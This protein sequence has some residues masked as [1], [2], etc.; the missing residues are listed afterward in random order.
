[1]SW[2]VRNWHLKLGAVALATVLYTG[3]VFSGSFTDGRISGV[4]IQ[5][6]NQPSGAYVISQEL[7]AV[8][9]HYR[10]SR[11][12]AETVNE[13]SFAATV[14]L[15]RYD[16]QRPGQPQSLPVSV[17]PL[18]SGVH[19]LDVTPATVKV[20]LDRLGSKEVDVV[21]DHGTVPDGLELGT[22]R[23]SSPTVTAR[24][25]SSFVSQVAR[26]EAVVSIDASGIDIHRQVELKPVDASGAV[27][28]SVELNPSV[29]TVDISVEQILTNKTL[30]VSVKLAGTPAAG[31]AITQVVTSPLTVTLRGAPTALSVVTDVATEPISVDGLTTSRSFTAKLVIPSG[32][33]L[34][35]DEPASVSVKVTVTA[36]EASRTYLVGVT[37]T[38]APAGGSCLPRI[39]QLAMTLS[40]PAPALANLKASDIT[41]VVDVS[42]LSPGSHTL[43]PT[44]TLPTGVSLISFA[45]AQVTVEVVA[46]TASP[47]P[48]A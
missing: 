16:M 30:P 17:S 40:G 34:A 29:V 8:E 46:P 38:G 14:D 32:L 9:V 21:V 6:I 13:N 36:E 24:G 12:V 19:V 3:L 4:P 39:G 45:P 20:T 15:S 37:C 43:T 10:R 7:P 47:S 44:V 18:V 1:M 27:V 22:P 5:R 28:Q 25:P 11:E 48:G 26:A 35:P 31:Y 41:P 33:Q 2:I 23:L 42:G